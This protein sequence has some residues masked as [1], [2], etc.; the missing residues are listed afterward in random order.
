MD[1]TI[2]FIT[3]QQEIRI[4][5]LTAAARVHQGLGSFA[6]DVLLTA[7]EFESYITDGTMP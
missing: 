7:Q 6:E 2:V 1:D 3:P 5:A 4:S